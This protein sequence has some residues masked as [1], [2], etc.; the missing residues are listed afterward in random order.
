MLTGLGVKHR[1][2]YLGHLL[3]GEPVEPDPGLVPVDPHGV[4]GHGS[5]SWFP[6]AVVRFGE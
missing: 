2:E 6:I 3:R 4:L 1:V 5:V